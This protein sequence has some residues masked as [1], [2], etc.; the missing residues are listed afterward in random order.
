METKTKTKAT[1]AL[2]INNKT[3]ILTDKPVSKHPSLVKKY[4]QIIAEQ[5]SYFNS[6]SYGTM[7]CLMDRPELTI[8]INGEIIERYY[9]NPQDFILT[10]PKHLEYGS[11]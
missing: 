3:W 7:Q 8:K 2:K 9:K 10:V 1:K 11:R 4:K 5:N 6:F